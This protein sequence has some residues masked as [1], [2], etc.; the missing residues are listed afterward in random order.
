MNPHLQNPQIDIG[1]Y[2]QKAGKTGV[3]LIHGL[4]ATSSEMRFISQALFEEGYTVSVPLLPGHGTSPYDLCNFQQKDWLHHVEGAYAHLE[5]YCDKIFICGTSMG[6]LLALHLSLK[7]PPPALILYAPAYRAG[8][9]LIH[10][11][12]YIKRFVKIREK[13]RSAENKPLLKERWQ[14]YKVDVLPA[15]S[16]LLDLQE[17]TKTILSRIQC[18]TLIFQGKHDQSLDMHGAQEVYDRISSRDKHLIWL[19]NS[20]HCLVMDEEWKAVAAETMDF[21]R[22]YE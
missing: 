15:V 21:I 6:A 20:T 12:P 5:T 17:S 7:K 13:T 18:P 9:K 19:E 11:A 4:Y 16:E 10:L 22:K 3:L 8:T 2:F 14:G 1:P